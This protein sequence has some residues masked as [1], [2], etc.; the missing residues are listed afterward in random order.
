MRIGFTRFRDQSNTQLREGVAQ[1]LLNTRMITSATLREG[2]R[3]EDGKPQ[4]NW[5]VDG[6]A[7]GKVRVKKIKTDVST[8]PKYFLE[9]LSLHRGKRLTEEEE[10]E[11]KDA[12]PYGNIY[13]SNLAEEFRLLGSL[14]DPKNMSV[15]NS[16]TNN[17][18]YGIMKFIISTTDTITEE[19]ELFPEFIQHFYK[20]TQRSFYYKILMKIMNSIETAEMWENEYFYDDRPYLAMALLGYLSNYLKIQ[21]VLRGSKG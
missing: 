4:F 21:G 16:P 12:G 7:K 8:S 14:L 10:E 20:D 9:P 1:V 5:S 11:N 19:S 13:K 3:E 2:I 17:I 18:S 6:I 15:K